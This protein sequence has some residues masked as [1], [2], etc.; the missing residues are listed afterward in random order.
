MQLSQKH[1]TFSHSFAE[2]LKSRRN[3]RY[4]EK[5]DEPQR[6]CIS[7]IIASENVVR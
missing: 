2:S 6:F 7:E 1:K 3:F 4:F 5:K